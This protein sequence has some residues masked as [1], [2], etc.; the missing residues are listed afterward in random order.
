MSSGPE[1]DTISRSTRTLSGEM[2][3]PDVGVSVEHK[4][5]RPLMETAQP[6]HVFIQCLRKSSVRHLLNFIFRTP[7][8]PT[9]QCVS[10]PDC[11]R[12]RGAVGGLR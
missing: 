10:H 6:V 3:V 12:N 11:V 7:T 4:G 2:S 1:P 9:E 8:N 5:L